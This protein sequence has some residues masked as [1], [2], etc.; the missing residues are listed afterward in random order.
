MGWMKEQSEPDGQQ[1]TDW[2][3][4]LLRDM[5]VESWGQQKSEGKPVPHCWRFWAPPH[6][7]AWRAKRAEAWAVAAMRKK[8]K[9]LESRMRLVGASIVRGAVRIRGRA[10]STADGMRREERRRDEQ[11]TEDGDSSSATMMSERVKGQRQH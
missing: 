6:V 4:I 3:S 9:T 1:M 5:Q 7:D 8:R 2:T 11:G 10:W